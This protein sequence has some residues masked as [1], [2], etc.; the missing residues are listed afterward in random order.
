MKKALEAII[1]FFFPKVKSPKG[2]LEAR[3]WVL[4]LKK[5]ALMP[6]LTAIYQSL[7]AGH[8]VIDFK[9]MGAMALSGGVLY[10]LR[11]LTIGAKNETET[12]PE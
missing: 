11:C 1:L 12:K 7:E 3:D 10:I 5:A 9:A 2:K 4:G 8:V 6:P